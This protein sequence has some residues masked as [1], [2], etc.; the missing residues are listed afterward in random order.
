MS[1]KRASTLFVPLAKRVRT[2]E[3]AVPPADTEPKTT[4]LPDFSALLTSNDT[5]QQRFRD[6]IELI[7]PFKL[8]ALTLDNPSGDVIQLFA[9]LRDWGTDSE[10]S[11][12]TCTTMIGHYIRTMYQVS[13]V[14]A[15]LE[16]AAQCRAFVVQ[17]CNNSKASL[18]RYRRYVVLSPPERGEGMHF[19]QVN[20]CTC[21]QHI[22]SNS[23][24]RQH[25]YVTQSVVSTAQFVDHLYLVMNI[26]WAEGYRHID[27]VC[28]SV[29]GKR[30][31][32]SAA[33]SIIV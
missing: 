6:D 27:N 24:W 10:A 12:K 15:V 16:H 31:A 11:R 29:L 33:G 8:P 14:P 3:K 7:D 2:P 21:Q 13:I 20:M 4:L 1:S 30:A 19:L 18:S 23:R 32:H 25:P 5:V 26:L 28:Y 9:Y 17:A 22:K